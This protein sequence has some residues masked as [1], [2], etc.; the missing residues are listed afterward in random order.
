[1]SYIDLL[2]LAHNVPGEVHVAAAGRRAVLG[3]GPPVAA[4]L[5]DVQA[6]SS[7]GFIVQGL[8]ARS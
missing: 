5:G 8:A 6:N 7:L 4:A 2:H 3:N 1:L